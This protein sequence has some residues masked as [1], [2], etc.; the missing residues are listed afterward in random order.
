MVTKWEFRV[1]CVETQKRPMGRHWAVLRL[2]PVSY[3]KRGRVLVVRPLQGKEDRKRMLNVD[4][5]PGFQKAVLHLKTTHTQETAFPEH[6]VHIQVRFPCNFWLYWIY[7][8]IS[9]P[10][11]FQRS[12]QLGQS[13]EQVIVFWTNLYFFGFIITVWLRTCRRIFPGRT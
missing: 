10:E 13:M 2:R 9:K 5:V 1:I 12:F 6:K 8:K 11:P 3:R 4:S 7:A